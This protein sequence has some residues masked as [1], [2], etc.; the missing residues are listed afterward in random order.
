MDGDC[1]DH[2]ATRTG[3]LG[4]VCKWAVIGTTLTPLPMTQYRR[5]LEVTW[6]SH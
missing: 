2:T 3:L 5:V 6:S 1:L 4:I